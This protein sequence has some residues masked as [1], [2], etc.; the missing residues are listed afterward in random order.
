M[1]SIIFTDVGFW[2]S[3]FSL[4]TYRIPSFFFVHIIPPSSPFLS[5]SIHFHLL[6]FVFGG[7]LA[8]SYRSQVLRLPVAPCPE[9]RN[10][11]GFNYMTNQLQQP[12]SHCP[13]KVGITSGEAGKHFRWDSTIDS[14]NISRRQHGLAVL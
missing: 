11:E 14:R 8:R 7:S 12:S 6:R 10:G 2:T 4:P 13:W 1:R 5:S 9:S 3:S